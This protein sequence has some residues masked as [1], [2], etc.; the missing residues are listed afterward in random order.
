MKYRTVE[1]QMMDKMT[2]RFYEDLIKLKDL[3]DS[4]LKG[5]WV[6]DFVFSEIKPQHPLE[7]QPAFLSKDII[8]LMELEKENIPDAEERL[9]DRMDT[10]KYLIEDT[11]PMK[12][13]IVLPCI[14]N[15]NSSNYH[16]YEVLYEGEMFKIKTIAENF[17]KSDE[18][19]DIVKTTMARLLYFNCR[20]YKY[21]KTNKAARQEIDETYFFHAS[22]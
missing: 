5:Y 10:V 20:K 13:V 22:N 12:G 14:P 8:L 9:D 2:E 18:V 16:K 19:T 21:P 6:N 7:V 4:Y 17:V 15:P 3:A 1:P 11:M